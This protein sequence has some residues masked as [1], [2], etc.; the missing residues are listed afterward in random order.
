LESK[1]KVEPQL[2]PAEIYQA[3]EYIVGKENITQDRAILETYSKYSVDIVSYLK[4]HTKD[5]SNIPACVVLPSTTEEVQ[6]IV[7]VANKHKIPF[8]PFTNGQLGIAN[9]PTKPLPTLCI[10]FSRMNKILELNERNMMARVQPYVDYGQ[11]QADAMKVGLWNGGT[12]LA[13][14]L[15]K[16][17]SQ[18]VLGGLFQTSMK[19]GTIGKNIVSFKM[20][21]PDGEILKTGSSS[22][23]SVDDFWEFAPGPDLYGLFR[24]SSG[25]LGVITELTVKLHSW[26]GG[27]ELPEPPAGR[28]SIQPYH[29]EKYDHA[30]PPELHRLYWIEYKNLASEIKALREVAH[31]G[32]GI[33]LNAAGVYNCYYCTP[34]QEHTIKRFKENFFP[35]YNIYIICTGITSKKQLDYADKVI[36]KIVL[37][38]D[39]K[40]LSEDYK[41]EVLEVLSNWNLDCIRHVCGYRMS[42]YSYL[43]TW[44]CSGVPIIG[45]DAQE[46]WTESINTFG[47][48]YLTDRGGVDNTPF[49]YA[50]DPAGRNFFTEADVYPNPLDPQALQKAQQLIMF[51]LGRT[52]GKKIGPGVTG[53][54]ASFEPFTSFFPEMGPNTYLFMRTLRKVFDPNGVCSPGRQVFTKEE[55]QAVPQPMVEA[56]NKLRQMNELNPIDITKMK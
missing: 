33:G 39:G 51:S 21:L 19:Y 52:I 29:Q 23:D 16:I 36:K 12:P 43:D 35:P 34:T 48:T 14:S 30:P 3:L 17:S 40:L 54:G 44:F 41:P 2:L 31:S 7:R 6:A 47:E 28:P 10:H 13:T 38:T 9:Y 5:P 50:T 24:G 55:L 20:V 11:L 46:I 49:L 8:V 32:I 26:A 15:C 18:A 22:V 45:K 53:F 25:T 37:E 4:K 42:R 27:K 1:K 56:I